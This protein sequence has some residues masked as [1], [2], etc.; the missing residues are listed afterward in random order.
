MAFQQV[1]DIIQE[2][3][4]EH[5]KVAAFYEEMEDCVEQ[6]KVKMLLK[7]MKKH[8]DELVHCF[9]VYLQGSN[10]T[11]KTWFQYMPEL[12]KASELISLTLSEGSSEDE[13]L[14]LFDDVNECFIAR[15]SKLSEISPSAAVHEL[16]DEMVRMEQYEMTRESWS[17][18]M[19]DDM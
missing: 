14:R 16:F 13:V 15:Y 11:L 3:Y 6:S 10:S 4:K 5:C 8:E 1:K 19:M 18:T 7:S 2:S 9:K 12:P 17:K